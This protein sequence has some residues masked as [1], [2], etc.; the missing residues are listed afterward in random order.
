MKLVLFDWNGTLLDDI[1]I[2][3][4]AVKETFKCFGK[5]PPTVEQYFKELEGDYASIYKSRGIEASRDEMNA[6]Y[7]PYYERR[8]NE[9]TLF[10]DT[11]AILEFLAQKGKIL[12]LITGQKEYLTSPLLDKFGINAFF[13]YR[14]F[15][16]TNKK[17]VISIILKKTGISHDNCCYVGDTPSDI[18]HAKQA[19]VISIALASGYLQEGL[20][21]NAEPQFIIH[22]LEELKNIAAN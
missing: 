1:P 6:V 7:E 2:W 20:L 11:C 8:M 4:E 16:V 13:R 21:I 19:G 3:Y 12:G 22:N 5:E 9:A 18:R 15:H 14:E 17:E 10:P